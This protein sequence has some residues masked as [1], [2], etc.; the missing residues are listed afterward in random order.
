MST[1]AGGLFHEDV[2]GR[3]VAGG[4]AVGGGASGGGTLGI[5]I[6][7]VVGGHAVLGGHAV[8]GGHTVP[9]GHAVLGEW[10]GLGGWPQREVLPT[11][12]GPLDRLLPAGG[13]HRGALIEWIEDGAG[14]GATGGTTAGGVTAL[15]CAVA[16]TI[17]RRSAGAT[18]IVIDRRGW[19]HP[20]AVL[21]WL[22]SREALDGR[23]ALGGISPS[24][25]HV[26]RPAREDD[27]IWAI[28]QA[29]RCPGVAAV[30]AWPGR[31]HP[32]AMRR[33]QL[34]ARS[35]G[36]VGLLV[37]P[38]H[39]RRDPSWAEARVQVTPAVAPAGPPAAGL[40]ADLGVRRL[41]VALVGGPWCG[42]AGPRCDGEAERSD[43]LLIDMRTGREPLL[44]EAALFHGS[45]GRQP[46]ARRHQLREGWSCRA[47]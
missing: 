33:W 12:F 41:R 42:G 14:T 17:A 47:S 27:E 8:P 45:T 6:P 29:L 20:P 28:D 37:R 2:A 16:C 19:F 15:A 10:G 24:H 3:A 39:T 7:G 11:G 38:A 22:N 32:T 26:A 4:H 35:G 31:V 36:A 1:S 5:A 21:P 46:A 44:H 40:Q 9:G 25:L 23:E 30:L 43:E 34:A 18:V 13:V